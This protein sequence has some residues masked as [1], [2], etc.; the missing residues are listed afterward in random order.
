MIDSAYADRHI[1]FLFYSL[2]DFFGNK[3]LVE[4]LHFKV[5]IFTEIQFDV[6]A[7]IIQ[8]VHVC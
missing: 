4:Y 1:I 6:I 2:I 8:Q 7:F 5:K 3:V